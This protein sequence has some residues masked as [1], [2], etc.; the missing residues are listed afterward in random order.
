ME[1]TTTLGELADWD[2]PEDESQA[3]MR[4]LSIIDEF[5]PSDWR[6]WVVN[7]LTY[8]QL[9]GGRISADDENRV[10]FAIPTIHLACAFSHETPSSLSERRFKAI[11]RKLLKWPI[12]RALIYGPLATLK[13]IHPEGVFNGFASYLPKL[14]P[15][16]VSRE[17]ASATLKANT[18]NGH[19][20][21][22]SPSSTLSR[23]RTHSPARE[24]ETD[25]LKGYMRQ[26]N[27]I[28]SRLI[29]ISEV[30]S[31]HIKELKAPNAEELND[32]APIESEA[33]K[34]DAPSVLDGEMDYLVSEAEPVPSPQPGETDLEI[35]HFYSFDPE[36]VET[37][38]KVGPA[39]PILVKQGTQC[40]R[41]GS[42][43][44]QNIRY[45][46]V[47]K[48]FQATPVF[49]SLKT[50]SAL[51]MVTPPWQS[52]ILLEKMDLS[53]GAITN[54]L[55]QQRHHFTDIF[56]QAS[57]EAKRYIN[58]NFLSKD[59]AFRKTSDALLQYTCGK[60]AEVLQQRRGVYKPSNKTLNEL[61]QAI[62]PSSTQ[63]FSE[64]Q[65][66]DLIKEQGGLMKFFPGR[67]RTAYKHKNITRKEN[68]PVQETKERRV[69]GGASY[70]RPNFRPHFQPDRSSMRPPATGGRRQYQP[71]PGKQ[72]R[73]RF[74]GR[75]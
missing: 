25:S 35:D 49:T 20:E 71:P 33:N 17:E 48:Q 67:F 8:E 18:P 43:G 45:A 65:L 40:Q 19:P 63:L 72:R 42:D 15:K 14:K 74:D 28:L 73:P 32:H 1:N 6:N 3:Y 22:S 58:Q 60:R 11:K 12:A 16:L 30:N 41:L 36:T 62:P 7:N 66:S 68:I 54:G 24:L 31:Q 2:P 50:N 21:Y 64:P 53:L 37:E 47:Q 46:D 59:S 51:A 70:R 29:E 4:I 34:W 44:W 75:K 56:N 10:R 23:E 39:N 69:E 52:I 27:Q 57:P 26:Q 61:L 9:F 55:L 13:K 38:A 5:H